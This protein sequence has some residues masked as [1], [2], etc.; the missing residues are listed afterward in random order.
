[1][2]GRFALEDRVDEMITEW[3]L[4]G[5]TPHSWAPEG[6]RPSWNI[7]PGQSIAVLLETA[8]R[9]GGAVA[10]RVLEGLWSLLPPWAT[11]PRLSYPTFNARAETLTTTRSWSGAVAAHRCVIPA[12]AY[13]EWSGPKGSRIPHVV[14]APDD[15][16]SRWP[17]CTR[18]GGPTGRARGG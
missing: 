14:H 13:Y 4:D 6:W 11:T 18:G 1:M 12:S 5:N 15:A 16:P 3:V 9:P 17:D 2:C 8:L 10:P 7:S